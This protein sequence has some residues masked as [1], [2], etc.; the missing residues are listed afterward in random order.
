M[1]RRQKLQE[2]VLWIPSGLGSQ[3]CSNSP[4]QV[5]SSLRVVWH[6]Q[7]WSSHLFHDAHAT[8]QHI[9]LANASVTCSHGGGLGGRSA[10]APAGTLKE[11][12]PDTSGG[13]FWIALLLQRR[14]SEILHVLNITRGISLKQ[15]NQQT[16]WL[17]VIDE[18]FADWQER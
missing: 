5:K 11:E 3:V 13:A 7:A 15:D 4:R 16:D 9:Q 1:L 10:R 14:C 2:G 8:H 18:L 17:C 12:H 6:G